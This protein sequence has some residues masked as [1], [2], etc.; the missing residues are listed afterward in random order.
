MQDFISITRLS[1]TMTILSSMVAP[2]I[3]ILACGSLITTTSQRL[4]NVIE[5]SRFLT[6]ELKALVKTEESESKVEEVSLL[7]FCWTK[8]LT[9]PKC[10]N[11]PSLCCIWRSA[12]SSLPA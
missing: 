9:A 2:V 10:C 6:D 11:A 1:Q 3:L 4:T 8:P 12:F 5:R 7:F